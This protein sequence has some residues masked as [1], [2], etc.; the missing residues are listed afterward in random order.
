MIMMPPRP[1]IIALAAL[2]LVLPPSASSRVIKGSTPVGGDPT[3]DVLFDPNPAIPAL[4]LYAGFQGVL[5]SLAKCPNELQFQPPWYLGD[6]GSGLCPSEYWNLATAAPGFVL[7]AASAWLYAYAGANRLVV[8]ERAVGVV[9]V[10]ADVTAEDAREYLIAFNDIEAYNLLPFGLSVTT[11]SEG[12]SKFFP[13][14]WD[15]NDVKALLEERVR[16]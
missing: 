5:P 4:T 14:F 9:N 12:G 13:L 15:S 11:K 6:G 2:L 10:G 16:L 1:S 3:A 8:T 7:L